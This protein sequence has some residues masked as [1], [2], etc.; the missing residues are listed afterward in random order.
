MREL[1]EEHYPEERR[2]L[3]SDF[4]SRRRPAEQRRQSPRKSADE[5]APVSA[6]FERSVEEQI[7]RHRDEA[8]ERRQRIDEPRQVSFSGQRNGAAEKERS[9]RGQSPGGQGAEFGA[10]HQRVQ[11]ALPILIERVDAARKQ[12]D[13]DR[14]TKQSNPIN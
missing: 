3:D 5:G 4:V 6:R 12:R 1:P 11:V 7:A 13:A 10:P 2:G 14:R 8:P 9:R